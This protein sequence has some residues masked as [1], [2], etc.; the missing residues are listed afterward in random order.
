VFDNSGEGGFGQLPVGDAH[1]EDV[2][3]LNR[4]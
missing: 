3:C 2:D 4:A 1:E